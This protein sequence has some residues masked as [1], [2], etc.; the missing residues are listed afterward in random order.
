VI[1]PLQAGKPEVR[2]YRER[3]EWEGPEQKYVKWGKLVGPFSRA[4]LY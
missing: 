1:T 3:F 4:P 2:A